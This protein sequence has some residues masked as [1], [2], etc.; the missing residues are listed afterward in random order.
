M[1]MNLSSPT[2]GGAPSS[3]H[4]L[5][6]VLVVARWLCWAWMV[7]VVSFGHD[8]LVHP[9]VAWIAVGVMLLVASGGNP[10]GSHQS[11]V[12]AP[13][14]TGRHRGRP[15][16]CARDRRRLGLRARSRVHDQP[17]PGYGVAPDRRH[18]RGSRLGPTRRWRGGPP[19]RAGSPALC[20]TERLLPIRPEAPRGIAGHRLVLRSQRRADRLAGH[21]APA[22]RGNDQPPP[23]SRRDGEGAAR[24]RFAD[25]R[26]RGP[27]ITSIR[28]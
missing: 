8:A 18:L 26:A 20:G 17:E 9:V 12:A 7:G 10:P 2:G 6:R 21:V 24:H 23:R 19:V 3:V 13:T 1:S 14:V 16:A 5:Q 28:S 27:P 15:R 11:R 4:T 25:A 22:I